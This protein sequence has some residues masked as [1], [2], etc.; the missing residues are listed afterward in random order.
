[1]VTQAVGSLYPDDPPLFLDRTPHG[2]YD[3]APFQQRLAEAGFRAPAAFE[4]VEARSRAAHCHDPAI[5]YCQGT[6]L[7][8]EI[9]ARDPDGLAGATNVASSAIAKQFG[10][11]DVDGRVR[12]FVLTA[13]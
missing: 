2:H 7:R 8:D 12:G 11:T 6:P 5:A 9:I 10:E 13:S 4:P 1:M 3:P